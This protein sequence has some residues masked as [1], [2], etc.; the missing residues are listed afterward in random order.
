MKKGQSYQYKI[1]S[2]LDSYERRLQAVEDILGAIE[3]MFR[4]YRYQNERARYLE[5]FLPSEYALEEIYRIILKAGCGGI[6]L[7]EISEKD[8]GT[9]LGDISRLMRKLL[10]RGL[11]RRE[12][13]KKSGER[14]RRKLIYYVESG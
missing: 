1:K 12:R 4:R 3:P 13:E 10:A 5:G 6:T 9:N 2:R 14:G 7:K 11:V 8:G